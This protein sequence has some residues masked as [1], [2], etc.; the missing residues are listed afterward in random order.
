MLATDNHSGHWTKCSDSGTLTVQT[1]NV[2]EE[3]PETL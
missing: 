1:A 2:S 3:K